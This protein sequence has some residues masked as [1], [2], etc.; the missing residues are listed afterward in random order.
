MAFSEIS[1][2]SPE[3]S[4][5]L[6]WLRSAPPQNRL[7]DQ[8]SYEIALILLATFGKQY[9]RALLEK[10]PEKLKRHFTEVRAASFEIQEKLLS[11]D[12][13]SQ[14]W[15]TT[16]T[17]IQNMG[18]NYFGCFHELRTVSF[19]IL[20]FPQDLLLFYPN[21]E[22]S[23]FAKLESTREKGFNALKNYFKQS[24]DSMD[25]KG[26]GALNDCSL[27]PDEELAMT[28]LYFSG[29]A[30]VLK[31]L[32]SPVVYFS[33]VV[34]LWSFLSNQNQQ[35]FQRFLQRL[36]GTKWVQSQQREIPELFTFDPQDDPGTWSLSQ[37]LA[38]GSTA[39]CATNFE[40]EP[41]PRVKGKFNAEFLGSEETRSDFCKFSEFP[42]LFYERDFESSQRRSR[43]L[44]RILQFYFF[45]TREFKIPDPEN[46]ELEHP[47]IPETDYPIL[48][49]ILVFMKFNL[50]RIAH[51]NFLVRKWERALAERVS[52]GEVQALSKA[53]NCLRRILSLITRRDISFSDPTDEDQELASDPNCWNLLF[54]LWQRESREVFVTFF[55]SLAKI[56]DF[57]LTLHSVWAFCECNQGLSTPYADCFIVACL[58]AI[59]TLTEKGVSI[60]H[61]EHLFF[62]PPF[63]VQSVA[64]AAYGFTVERTN[65]FIKRVSPHLFGDREKEYFLMLRNY[66]LFPQ[67]FLFELLDDCQGMG[68]GIDPDLLIHVFTKRHPPCEVTQAV[69][70]SARA[71]V[72]EII[73]KSDFTD[74]QIF[75]LYL[76]I[77]CAIR[78]GKELEVQR[79]KQAIL[80][81]QSFCP[82]LSAESCLFLFRYPA[83]EIVLSHANC[84]KEA[85]EKWVA[86]EDEDLD[87]FVIDQQ[88]YD[89]ILQE[90]LQFALA[91]SQACPS[92]DPEKRSLRFCESFRL[93]L[94]ASFYTSAQP[95]TDFFKLRGLFPDEIDWLDSHLK[96]HEGQLLFLKHAAVNLYLNWQ[97]LND[98]P[99][100]FM[101]Y[102]KK[103][104]TASAFFVLDVSAAEV[105][106]EEKRVLFYGL[107]RRL[108][109]QVLQE[110]STPDAL[111]TA[112]PSWASAYVGASQDIK[113]SQLGPEFIGPIRRFLSR[114]KNENRKLYLR[115]IADPPLPDL[116]EDPEETAALG[117][118][119]ES[120]GRMSLLPHDHVAHPEYFSPDAEPAFIEAK[121][122]LFSQSTPEPQ[123]L[124]LNL[125]TTDGEFPIFY[126][127]Q[128]K[129]E[130]IND[131]LDAGNEAG[132]YVTLFC[133]DIRIP[134]RYPPEV[135]ADPVIFAWYFKFH[136]LLLKAA[137]YFQKT[138]D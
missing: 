15:K 59:V 61:P 105:S 2:L 92:P 63:E 73:E 14:L 104:K 18:G 43:I 116:P 110:E 8:E 71:I 6:E 114:V 125:R 30:I 29:G 119:Y 54:F 108:A 53:W 72:Q 138:M 22:P 84:L 45:L 7:S 77:L 133:G 65:R 48:L 98:C 76:T 4:K 60:A 129:G 115:V 47:A 37:Y 106:T 32:K 21:L 74:A 137:Y 78:E 25:H 34:R 121:R 93:E 67:V 28:R 9:R 124:H 1:A 81:L 123:S 23:V 69:R 96:T 102:R 56:H 13:N 49:N 83:K 118:I 52:E 70:D 101:L 57:Q 24:V 82:H 50:D 3:P 55:E 35:R 128:S 107:L 111:E 89:D 95:L 85:R 64:G 5:Q 135:L 11:G 99:V 86:D 66:I 12:A 44:F 51:P 130:W 87:R 26:D 31:T 46:S 19:A 62:S 79:V 40:I 131:P 113:N 97:V 10:M 103:G 109:Q 20:P 88:K 122:A 17:V 134:L 127:A 100:L 42:S 68:V 39:A 94:F 33:E 80:T 41:L 132:K 126:H 117:Q 16:S 58:H 36:P 91:L 27:K 136:N 38:A 112:D 75:D 90:I 120:P